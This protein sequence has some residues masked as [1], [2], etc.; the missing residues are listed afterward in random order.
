MRPTGDTDLPLGAPMRML[1]SPHKDCVLLVVIE[2]CF[3]LLEHTTDY[4]SL[5]IHQRRQARQQ[6]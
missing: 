5:L 4:E 1:L 2:D 6:I 3:R